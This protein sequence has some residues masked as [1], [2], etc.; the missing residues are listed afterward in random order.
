MVRRC[1]V[2]CYA[3]AALNALLC[4]RAV[5]ANLNV[6]YVYADGSGNHALPVGARARVLSPR[7]PVCCRKPK[8]RYAVCSRRLWCSAKMS[9]DT[10][11]EAE[12]TANE[13][14]QQ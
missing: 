14:N 3:R 2:R 10:M 9:S 7:Y 11:P 6:R 8:S 1:R 5:S 12:R 13:R 4:A